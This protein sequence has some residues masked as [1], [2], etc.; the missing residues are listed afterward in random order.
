MTQARKTQIDLNTTP[1]Y[2]CYSRCVRRAFLCGLDRLTN[3]SFDHRK[4]W[5]V[6]RLALLAE[7]FAIDVVAYSIMSNHYHVI[8]RVDKEKA[9]SWE[10]HEVVER[11]LRLYK[12]C[13]LIQR[14]HQKEELSPDELE[15]VSIIVADYQ[16]RLYNISEFM[17]YLNQSIARQANIEDKCTGRF[18][19][20]RFGCQALLDETALLTC[21]LYVDL[22]P[23]RAGI[24]DRL[25]TSD[26][27]SIQQRLFL[28]ARSRQKTNKPTLNS[29]RRFIRKLKTNKHLTNLPRLQPL[30]N[31]S[32]DEF[33]NPLPCELETYFELAD[34]AGRALRDDKKG[35]IPDSVKPILQQLNTNP[36]AILETIQSYQ[37]RFKFAVGP[38]EKLKTFARQV[39]K[40]WL[41]GFRGAR[42]LYPT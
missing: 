30:I 32:E 35:V 20:G 16:K 40:K 38:I 36:A 27:T 42:L 12:G 1:Y 14:F 23:I 8:L 5:L 31:T 28:V 6:D 22:N 7:A 2:H 34:W 18:W 19:E 24:C 4:Q 25:E 11:W 21:M 26:Y 37:K 15:A 39:Q 29:E 3:K 17:A 41:F 10:A 13:D 33:N 9:K